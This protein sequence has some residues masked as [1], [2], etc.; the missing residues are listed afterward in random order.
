ME[1]CLLSLIHGSTEDEKKS[2]MYLYSYIRQHQ[3]C[4]IL[5]YIILQ[6]KYYNS[7]MIRLPSNLLLELNINLMYKT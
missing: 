1:A 4:T 3:S 6:L 5:R 2:V 7:N